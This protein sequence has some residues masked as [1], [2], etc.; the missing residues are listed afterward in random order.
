MTRATR[1]SSI[2]YGKNHV[3]LRHPAIIPAR[4]ED[5]FVFHRI[6]NYDPEYSK[7]I[8]KTT[9]RATD[10]TIRAVGDGE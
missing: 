6:C 2:L 7:A 4:T 9:E 8:P 3:R 10:A 1:L 5:G